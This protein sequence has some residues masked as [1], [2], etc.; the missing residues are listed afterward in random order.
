M[1]EMP[2]CRV[3]D[4][5]HYS[6]LWT[7]RYPEI[8]ALGDGVLAVVDPADRTDPSGLAGAKVTV[9]R[10]N[11]TCLELR[12]DHAEAPSGTLGIFFRGLSPTDVPRGS[13]IEWDNA[14]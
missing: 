13:T 10:P 2:T 6:G 14:S 3:L 9:M 11:A 7:H 1:S 4:T 5:I 8:A 12:V